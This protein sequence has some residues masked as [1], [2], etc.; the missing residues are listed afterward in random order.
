MFIVRDRLLWGNVD[1]AIQLATDNSRAITHVLTIDS[2]PVSQLNNS[3]LY[4]KY[5]QALDTPF[6]DLLD[7]IEQCVQFINLGVDQGKVLVH[8]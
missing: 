1:D 8:W 4:V 3:P 5:I 2:Q 6:T 7:Q